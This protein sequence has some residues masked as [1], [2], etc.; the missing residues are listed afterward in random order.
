MSTPSDSVTPIGDDDRIML[1]KMIKANDAENNTAKIRKLR[2]SRPLEED[3]VNMLNLRKKHYDL[4]RKNPAMYRNICEKRCQ[5]MFK[6]YT[7]IFNKLF[8]EEIDEQMLYKLIGMLRHIENGR[9]DQ[10]EAS[11][12]VGSILKDIYVDSALRHHE[13]REKQEKKREHA[14]NRKTPA[15]P[16]KANPNANMSYSQFKMSQMD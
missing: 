4:K 8:K 15:K 10:H 7:N 14:Q 6:N 5:F 2:H 1:D 11:V 9:V 12:Q 16:K 3:L 13:K